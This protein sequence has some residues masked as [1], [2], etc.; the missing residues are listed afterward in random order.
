MTC[1]V[2]NKVAKRFGKD[3]K[4]IQR[5]RCPLCRK[6]FRDVPRVEGKYL[7]LDKAILCI[8]LLC[9]GNSIRSIERVTD[10]HR[11][12][13]I[14]LLVRVGAKCERL[15]TDLIKEVPVK[16]VQ[17]DELWGFVAKKERHKTL[18]ESN[19]PRLGDAYCFVAIE[20]ESKVV[21]AWHLG[22][23]TARD[24]VAFTEK[25]L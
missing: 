10:V 14:D 25:T 9:E 4:G 1:Y 20:R 15:M 21:L 23:R 6:T 16:D 13:I 11:D 3:R 17:A 8:K 18:Q 24:T 22:R 2:C 12:T 7:P 19:N 5:F